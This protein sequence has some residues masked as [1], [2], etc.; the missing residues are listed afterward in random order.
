MV[1]GV[2]RFVH[3]GVETVLVDKVEFTRQFV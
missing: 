2:F 3:I 1:K